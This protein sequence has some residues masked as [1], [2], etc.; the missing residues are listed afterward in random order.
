MKINAISHQYNHIKANIQ[1]KNEIQ[2]NKVSICTV[3][4][5]FGRDLVNYRNENLPIE[6]AKKMPKG[7]SIYDLISRSQKP[8][9]ILGQ[10]ANSVVY[11]IPQLDDYVL[12]VL[13][14]DDPNKI[15]MNEFPSDVNLGQPVWQDKKT[16]NSYFEKNRRK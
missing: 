3:P 7:T 15:N 5:H 1:H 4:V 11:K 2:Q 8:E 14:K 12:K 10:G 9:N 13:N 16:K 6:I